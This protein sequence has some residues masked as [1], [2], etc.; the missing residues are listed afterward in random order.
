MKNLHTSLFNFLKN[1]TKEGDRLRDSH[2]LRTYAYDATVF[3]LEKEPVENFTVKKITKAAGID[4]IN[5]YNIFASWLFSVTINYANTHDYNTILLIEK[6]FNVTKSNSEYKSIKSERANL[7]FKYT[8]NARALKIKA[9]EIRGDKIRK[10]E[11]ANAVAVKEA[12]TSQVVKILKKEL[13]KEGLDVQKI[14]GLSQLIYRIDNTSR[15]STALFAFLKKQ[16]FK[17]EKMIKLECSSRNKFN[18]NKQFNVE[19]EA[20]IWQVLQCGAYGLYLD[21]FEK[22]TGCYWWDNTDKFKCNLEFLETS[23]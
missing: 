19:F 5:Q 2:I 7:E 23:F 22:N 13:N 4:D 11:H 12:L 21:N 16:K 10:L 9:Q 17:L 18:A 20:P 8:S 3:V 15:V 14:R 6:K 1:R